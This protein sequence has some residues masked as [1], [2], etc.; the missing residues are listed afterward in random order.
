MVFSALPLWIIVIDWLRPG[1]RAPT[2]M[3]AAGLLLGFAGVA[4]ILAPQRGMHARPTPLGADVLLVLASISWAAGAVLSRQVR[5]RGSALLPVARQ[6]IVAGAVLLVLGLLHGDLARV[7]LGTVRPS[8]WL[9]FAYL[10]LIGS[11]TGYPVYIWLMRIC[12]PSKVATIPYANLLVAVA[13][14]WTLGHE[15][16][17]PRLLAG[18]GIVVASVAIVLRAKDRSFPRAPVPPLT[19][20]QLPAPGLRATAGPAERRR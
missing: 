12:P 13:A 7:H 17:T 15:T 4:L 2:R 14:G 3:V 1:G 18:T 5:S 6:M 20:E 19:E 8:A 16:L 9:G 11:A 10:L